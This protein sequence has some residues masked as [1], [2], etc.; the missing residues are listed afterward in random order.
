MPG[1]PEQRRQRQDR[2]EDQLI[3]IGRDLAAAWNR[4]GH[5]QTISARAG[6]EILRLEDERAES[7][8]RA[9]CP[10]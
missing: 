7:A 8:A 2:A 3:R 4:S 6:N 5:M 9:L 1:R 10:S